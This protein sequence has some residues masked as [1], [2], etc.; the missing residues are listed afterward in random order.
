MKI[1]ALSLALLAAQAPVQTTPPAAPVAAPTST[2]P[3][4][5]ADMAAVPG[6]PNLMQS[7]VPAV[8]DA[9]WQRAEQ[10]LEARSARLLDVSASGDAVLVATR[11][12]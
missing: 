1:L 3:T 11:F 12:G 6:R 5:S 8:P 2:P 9:G 4:S 10:L 7:G